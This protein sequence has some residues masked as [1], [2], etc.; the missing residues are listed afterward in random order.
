MKNRGYTLVELLITLF[1]LAGG[2]LGIALVLSSSSG[3]SADHSEA[4][5]TLE[6]NGFSNVSV[7]SS[8]IVGA[9]WHGCDK[10]D[11]AYHEADATN[12]LGKRVHMVVCCGGPM[13]FKGCT[14]RSK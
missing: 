2:S 10:E 8:G 9:S 5:R 7:T 14:V 13:S 3:C 12:S 4:V 6:N 11:G 1:F